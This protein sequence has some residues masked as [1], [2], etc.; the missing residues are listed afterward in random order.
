[1]ILLE[2]DQYKNDPVITQHI[3]WMINTDIFWYGKTFRAI[4]MELWKIRN[5]ELIAKSGE[6][7]SIEET[8]Y[9]NDSHTTFNDQRLYNGEE[10]QQEHSSP[11]VSVMKARH[12]KTGQENASRWTKK[13]PANHL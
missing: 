3:M 10:T 6:E 5:G 1:M 13:N 7:P 4:F 12:R 2:L 8:H 9:Y 11:K